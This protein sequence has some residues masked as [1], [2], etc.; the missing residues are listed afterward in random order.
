MAGCKA[1]SPTR[2]HF[3][4]ELVAGRTINPVV[5]QGGGEI[6]KC[7]GDLVTQSRNKG[8]YSDGDEGDHDAVFDGGG[9]LFFAGEAVGDEIAR[10]QV[11]SEHWIQLLR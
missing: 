9:A 4:A 3:A 7:G 1:V 6:G 10:V 2:H 11:Q 5:C 8:D